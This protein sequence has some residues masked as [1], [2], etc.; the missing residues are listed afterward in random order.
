MSN[1]I[2]DSL[3]NQIV[4]RVLAELSPQAAAS[5][6]AAAPAQGAAAAGASPAASGASPNGRAWL[7]ADMI[8]DRAA[9]GSAVAIGPNEH[10]TPAARD[11]AASRKIEVRRGRAPGAV[12]ADPVTVLAP[13]RIQPGVLTRTL[14][15]LASRPDAK[16]EAALSAA[17]RA[18]IATR[19]FAESRCWMVN[20][21]AMCDAIKAGEL[22]GGVLI[23]RYA[24]APMVL[25]G[26]IRGIR[27]VQ[28]VSV[29]AVEAA[30]RQFDANVVVI[31]HAVASVYEIRS[32]ID[33]F[34][35]G[36]RMGRDRTL[37]LDA[38]EEVEARAQP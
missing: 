33:R 9:G 8:A 1:G 10:L 7:T 14:G 3:V 34:A 21:R 6:G 20:A 36:R 30:L 2:S 18:G 25:V 23:D 27:P 4:Q 12:R 35:A 29:S 17:T 32:M 13:G 22:A 38:V 28:G 24:A 16:V 31:G 15:L 5:P 37:L 11:Y 19:G 26:K